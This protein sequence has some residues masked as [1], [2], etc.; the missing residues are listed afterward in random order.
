[1]KLQLKCN[2]KINPLGIDE[3][4]VILSVSTDISKK[5][6]STEFSLYK[7]QEDAEINNPFLVK[8]IN[9]QQ[10]SLTFPPVSCGTMFFWTA[11]IFCPKKTFLSEINYFETGIYKEHFSNT[12]IQN[13]NFDGHVSEFYQTFNVEKNLLRARLYI[14][15]LG[16]Y[17]SYINN[18]KTDN[19]FFKPSL[20]D[21]TERKNLK[22]CDYNEENF[23]NGKKSVCID[24]Y[25]I[26][27]FLKEGVNNLKVLLGTGYFYDNDKLKTD[28]SFA[29]GTPRLFFEIRLFYP[30]KTVN[31]LSSENCLCRNTSFISQ[32][33]AGDFWDFSAN[34]NSYVDCIKAEAPTGTPCE[35]LAPYDKIF[36][37]ICPVKISP[38]SE[39][40]V[41]DFGINHSGGLEIKVKGKRGSK[42]TVKYFEVMENGCPNYA[43]SRF[44]GYDLKTKKY[45][46]SLEQKGEYILSGNE[47][48]IFPLFHWNGYRYAIMFYEEPC[49]IISVKSLFICSETNVNGSF[50][51]SENTLNK[52]YNL[53]LISQKSNMHCGVPSDCPHREKLPYTGDG[54]LTALSCMY[55]MDAEYF[56]RKWLQDIINSQGKDGLIPY[57]APYLGG[58]GGYWWGNAIA[59]LPSVIFSFSGDKKI[60]ED[61]F[62][63]L[64]MW[65]KHCES[66]LDDKNILSKSNLSWVLGEWLTPEI[67]KVNVPF[68]NT[69]AMYYAILQAL[70]TTKIIENTSHSDYLK[71]LKKKLK[72][73]IN[74]N[75]YNHSTGNYCEGI[76]GENIL[77]AIFN[78][79][80]KKYSE[81]L[82]QNII[83]H[84]ENNCFFDTGI[85]LT[86]FL[87]NA[88]TD[89][90]RID[91]A[92]K[93]LTRKKFPSFYYM[94]KGETSLRESWDIVWPGSKKEDFGSY[95]SRNHPMFGSVVAYIIKNIAGLNLDQLFQNK[96]TV[97]PLM[98][99]FIKKARASKQTKNGPVSVS[100]SIN[101]NNFT[102][103]LTVPYGLTC[104]VI[105]PENLGK[106]LYLYHNKIKKTLNPSGDSFRFTLSGGIW[107][108]KNT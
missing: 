67:T 49:E 26:K 75:F 48:C 10:I 63:P 69:L 90:G 24:T 78:I 37:T 91:I 34:D 83:S 99:D 74:K 14:S 104:K 108:I 22:N 57:S 38:C 19:T 71:Q 87:L 2:G 50:S 66:M 88:L 95:V 77:P 42:L 98:I 92:Y 1:M 7:S 5:I 32:M 65:I 101:K 55:C 79:A 80:E 89:F 18:I 96:I 13:P 54:H 35:P 40:I 86:P 16:F 73:S 39:G 46:Y 6:L 70:K 52:L 56:Y 84:Y 36:K 97:K 100:Y 12:W 72:K 3:R 17:L 9:G 68:M 94:M 51:C 8:K 60:L 43:T 23:N 102:M 20:T 82:K 45:V 27:F 25:D 28:M 4:N 21:Y 61:S 41:Y 53:Y 15:G 64:I 59:V 62:I 31:I 105:L 47:D 85:I 106:Q 76:Q 29:F 44:D 81:R 107:T 11:R 58:G 103:N 33:F 30:N 93:L